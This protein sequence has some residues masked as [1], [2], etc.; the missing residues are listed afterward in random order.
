M[1]KL[2]STQEAPTEA[3]L[4][5][6]GF[7]QGE[8]PLCAYPRSGVWITAPDR[9]HGRQLR[10]HLL[11]CP[12][13]SLVW[14]D[15]PPLKLEM[16]KHYGQDYDRAIANAAKAP[17]HWFDP[18]NELLRHK[19][20]G[21]V[22]DLGCA[23]GGFL[24]TLKGPSWKLFGVEMSVD[25]AAAAQSRSGAKVFV[26]DV[27]DAPF[28]PESFDAITCFNVFEHVYEP[29]KVLAKVSEWLKPDGIFYTTM[30]NI[31]SAGARIFRSYWY[32]LE[33]PRHLFHFSPA[34]LRMVAQSVGLQ[35]VFV[36]AQRNLYFESSARYIA[37]E[38]L[39]RI[40]ISRPP[41]AQ[42]SAPSFL[43]RIIRKGFRLTI[44]PLLTAATSLAGDGEMISAVFTKERSIEKVAGSATSAF[45]H[46]DR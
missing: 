39:K 20:G 43:W 4:S 8:C 22:L 32:A 5:T 18:R 2:M 26:G 36:S 3:A 37:D 1:S 29:V 28:P 7:D 30:P 27:L 40:G 19:S 38:L 44:L 9:F 21:A 46:A 41:L 33:L 34:T 13:C 31:D 35:E 23:S 24:S 10:Y 45:N 6:K 11:R 12:A 42:A 25:A 17:D 16:T 14:L 15:E